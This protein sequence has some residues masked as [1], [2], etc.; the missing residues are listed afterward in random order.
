MTVIV[1]GLAAT[2]TRRA[3]LRAI[4]DGRGRISYNPDEKTVYDHDTGITVTN[5]CR[6][7]LGAGWI[8]ALAPDEARGPGELHFRTYYRLTDYGRAAMN[9]EAR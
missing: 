6:E 3:L 4:S 5:R 1:N 2:R 7:L 8:R 9:G